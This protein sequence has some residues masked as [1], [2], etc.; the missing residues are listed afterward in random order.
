MAK[1]NERA[2]FL[3]SAP[4]SSSSFSSNEKEFDS[5]VIEKAL[6]LLSPF[7]SFPYWIQNSPLIPFTDGSIPPPRAA[8]HSHGQ[9]LLKSEEA[10]DR[11]A[12]RQY[13]TRLVT[14]LQQMCAATSTCHLVTLVGCWLLSSSS[15][16]SLP[17]HSN[18]SSFL[19]LFFQATQIG[20]H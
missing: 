4:S 13:C 9:R 19:R 16:L 7:F 12:N 15:S 5:L 3:S 14:L 20:L 17:S 10:E 11:V 2:R 6:G 8:W 1:R 18:F